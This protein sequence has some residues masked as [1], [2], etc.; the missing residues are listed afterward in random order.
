MRSYDY[1]V[2][3][4]GSGGAAVAARLAEDP[5]VDVLLLEAGGTDARL[6]VRAPAAFPNQFHTKI[7]WDY[8]TLP[9]PGAGGRRIYEPRGKVLGGCSSMNAMLWMRG[10]ASDYDGWGLPGW[11]WA[12]VQPAFLRMEDHFLTDD[13]HGHGG[14]MRVTRQVD[15]DP[16]AELFVSAAAKAA[17]PLTDDVS[18]PDMHGVSI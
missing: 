14:P 15:H 12:D 10:A 5:S 9:E 16:M 13:E 6:E 18:G 7:D 3:G 4:S 11:S 1:I 8:H 17:A 2:V